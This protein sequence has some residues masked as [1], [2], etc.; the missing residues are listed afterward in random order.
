MLKVPDGTLRCIVAGSSVFRID[1]FSKTNPYMTAVVSELPDVTVPSEELTAMHRNLAG[2]F[3]K[4]LGFL[5]QA[6]RE[7]ETEVN[8]IN[9]SDLLTYFIASTMRLDTSDRQI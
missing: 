8:N 1:S 7:M 6:P 3:T 5:P 4:L 2:L 9:D